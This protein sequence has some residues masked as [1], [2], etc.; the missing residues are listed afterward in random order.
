MSVELISDPRFFWPEMQRSHVK[1]LVLLMRA[2][3]VD[4][5]IG[6]T[7]VTWLLNGN[8]TGASMEDGIAGEDGQ[9]VV[10]EGFKL[11]S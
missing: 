8:R 4:S 11:I 2:H 7:T 10:K 6:W 9:E 1:T 3:T 5:G